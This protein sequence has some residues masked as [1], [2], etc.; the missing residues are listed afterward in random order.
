[1]DPWLGI[2]AAVHRTGQDGRDGWHP[3][4]AIGL[5]DALAAASADRR[6]PRVG[7]PVDL[8]IT[9]RDPGDMAPGELRT[10]PIFGTLL[11]GRW[12]YRADCGPDGGTAAAARLSAPTPL[13]GHARILPASLS[14]AGQWR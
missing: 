10:L 3:E 6:A 12:T 13:M 5:P 2:A 11:A 7:D 8:V 14:G 9:D 1:M 4:Q